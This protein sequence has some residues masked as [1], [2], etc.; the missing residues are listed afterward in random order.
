M[1][2]VIQPI[3]IYNISNGPYNKILKSVGD[4]YNNILFT[5]LSYSMIKKL[6]IK[7]RFRYFGLGI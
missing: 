7:F 3:A 5:N 1:R 2:N 4:R 6:P